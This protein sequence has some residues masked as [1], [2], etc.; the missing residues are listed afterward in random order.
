MSL[1][2]F[3]KDENGKYVSTAAFKLPRALK[4]ILSTITDKHQ[5]GHMKGLFAQ[6]TM[7]SFEVP[8]K[9]KKSA[10]GKLEVEA[11]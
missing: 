2:N 8:E 11:A 1:K 9:K 10:T 3:K 4:Y 7:Q 6:A 5:R